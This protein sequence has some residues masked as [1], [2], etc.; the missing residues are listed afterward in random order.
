MAPGHRLQSRFRVAHQREGVRAGRKTG[1]ASP[2]WDASH[3]GKPKTTNQSGNLVYV[4]IDAPGA[5]TLKKSSKNRRRE[6]IA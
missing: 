5:E 3:T 6:K 1:E 4:G 2:C